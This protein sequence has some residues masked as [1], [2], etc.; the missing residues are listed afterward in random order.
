[1]FT[2]F[3]SIFISLIL[4]FSLKQISTY[5]NFIRNFI[6]TAISPDVK[7]KLHPNFHPITNIAIIHHFLWTLI[8]LPITFISI[9]LLISNLFFQLPDWLIIIIPFIT[10]SSLTP[11]ITFK[12]PHWLTQWSNN[13]I[14]S[15]QLV[16]LDNV[17]NQLHLIKNQLQQVVNDQISLSDSEL[18]QL[19]S[20]AYFLIS[21]SQSLK[22]NIELQSN[23]L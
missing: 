9:I 11:I 10:A 12:K 5:S 4:I 6:L 3:L 14:I 16:Q 19:Y 18:K 2:I 23:K 8:W 21:I 13:I 7:S 22:H 17:T 20:Q 1:M 15:T